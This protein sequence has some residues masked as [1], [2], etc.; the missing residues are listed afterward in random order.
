M[1][2]SV[3]GT[4]LTQNVSDQLSSKAY[5][6]LAARFPAKAP[7]PGPLPPSTPNPPS[8]PI[9]TDE[10]QVHPTHDPQPTV[11]STLLAPHV[12]SNRS[13]DSRAAAAG[14]AISI[15]GMDQ[16]PSVLVWKEVNQS[17]GTPEGQLV[18][19]DGADISDA[20]DWEAVRLAPSTQVSP[21]ACRSATMRRSLLCCE[22]ACCGC[23]C[24]FGILSLHVTLLQ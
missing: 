14:R 2:D 3:I 11:S 15:D 12:S 21:C 6:T 18:V 20:V 10:G 4:F 23:C 19:T 7:T 22:L 17:Y 9:P 1:L 8:S 24:W 5:M 16:A 13:Q